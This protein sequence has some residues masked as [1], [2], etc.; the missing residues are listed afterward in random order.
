MRREAREHR[1]IIITDRTLDVV[2]SKFGLNSFTI[3]LRQKP[4]GVSRSRR[5]TGSL[6][7]VILVLYGVIMNEFHPNLKKTTSSVLSVIL[8]NLCS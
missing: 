5:R 4:R 2:F 3:T 7:Q 8:I 1:L 6:C